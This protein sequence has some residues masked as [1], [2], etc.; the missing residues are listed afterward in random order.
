MRASS[1]HV[2]STVAVLLEHHAGSVQRLLTL[3]RDT[4]TGAGSTST[5]IRLPPSSV[6]S[7]AHR[8][9]SEYSPAALQGQTQYFRNKMFSRSL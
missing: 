9:A 2:R 6:S 4:A 7:P 5:G 8:S 1:S 3:Q